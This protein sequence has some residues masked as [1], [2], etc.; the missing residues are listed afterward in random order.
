MIRPASI[1]GQSASTRWKRSISSASPPAVGNTSTGCPQWPQRTRRRPRARRRSEY[2]ARS[3]ASSPRAPSCVAPVLDALPE[4]L[5]E[6]ARPRA[7]GTAPPPSGARRRA[8]SSVPKNSHAT[9]SRCAEVLARRTPRTRRSRSAGARS[10]RT[11]ASFS[12]VREV[13]GRR[14]RRTAPS[15]GSRA[16]A[17]W[18]PRRRSTSAGWP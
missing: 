11:R 14:S 6:L 13:A 15:R 7:P 10:R 4:Q 16:S 2:H 17:A 3:R 9:S 18:S 8:R 12:R 5:G 1:S